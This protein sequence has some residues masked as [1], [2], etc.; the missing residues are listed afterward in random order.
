MNSVSKRLATLCRWLGPVLILAASVS[1]QPG[2]VKLAIER[3]AEVKPDKDAAVLILHNTAEITISQDGKVKRD[4][5]WAGRI[6]A[7]AGIE[8]AVLHERVTATRKI[9]NLRGWLVKPDGQKVSLEKDWAVEVDLDRAAGYYDD[10]RSLIATFPDIKQ[11]DV[12]AF[13]YEVDEK[14][15]WT[16][17]HQSFT[18][19]VS[20]PVLWAQFAVTVPKQW[21]TYVS[22][23]GTEPVQYTSVDNRH[24]WSASDLEYRPEE[25][26]MPSWSRLSRW[27]AVICYEP[28]PGSVR[29]HPDWRSVAAWSRGLQDKACSETDVLA[30]VV[31]QV[32]G[33]R[34]EPGT[35]LA[36][37]AHYVR[38]NIRYV[39]V[40]IGAGR[41][42]PRPV[43][44]TLANRY[45]DCK[46]KVA[47]M[48]AM[49]G[50]AG[51]PAEAVDARIEGSVDPDFPSPFQFNHIIIAVPVASVPD[52]PP[53][54][55]ATVD[56]WLYFDPTDEAT[57]L[58]QLPAGLRG[59]Y[60]FKTSA[61]DSAVTRLPR[62]KPS[63]QKRVYRATAE[64]KS[65]YSLQ[66]EVAVVDY[67]VWR[68]VSRYDYRTTPTRKLIEV[69]QERFAEVMQ[70]PTL[71]DFTTGGDND[72]AWVKF[73]L[74]GSRI[75][76]EAGPY[77]LLNVDFFHADRADDLTSAER[78]H[79]IT[80]GA[81]AEYVT[82][83]RW[84]LPGGW[85]IDGKP[86]VIQDSCALAAVDCRVSYDSLITL[87]SKVTYYGGTVE[88]EEYDRAKRLNKNLRASHRVRTLLKKTGE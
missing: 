84:R 82:E 28:G 39:A 48:R 63:D 35:K 60:V 12:V 24:I 1:A 17:Y 79:P 68:T 2:W 7:R 64:L 19:Q 33:G 11:G 70:S 74:T 73:G 45:G 10:D 55:A 67:G 77:H 34:S 8:D 13:E 71:T 22:A 38:D 14:D 57:D 76:S 27:V 81:P 56:G 36:A 87:Q 72:S 40:E 86:E 5:C 50:R 52:L 3:G 21:Q 61:E 23:S 88:P 42:Q 9:K 47:L 37:I 85:V 26:F 25:P 78:V 58:G 51:I 43:A 6:L 30:G 46:D 49:L 41:F 69:W 54:P 18:F 53:Y 32:C 44:S 29:G 62:L 75:A 83:I 20:E 15:P 59:T 4:H 65:D 66:A 31:D 16:G 80:F